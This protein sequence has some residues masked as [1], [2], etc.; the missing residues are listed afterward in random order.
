MRCKTEETNDRVKQW[1]S[2]ITFGGTGR[3]MVSGG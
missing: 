1:C 2:D 3:R